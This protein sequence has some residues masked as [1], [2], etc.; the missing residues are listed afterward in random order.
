MEFPTTFEPQPSEKA[1]EWFRWASIGCGLIVIVLIGVLVMGLFRAQRFVDWGLTRLSNRVLQSLPASVPDSVRQEL[2]RKL[3]CALAAARDGRVP[4]ARI[5]ELARA[6][7]DALADRQIAVEELERVDALAGAI[8]REGG[9]V[10][11]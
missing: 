3:A 2:R 4:P 6:C 1:P 9:G 5:G 11:K 10:G 8:C 7:T